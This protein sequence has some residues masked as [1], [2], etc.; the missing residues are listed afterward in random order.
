MIRFKVISKE[1]MSLFR[2]ADTVDE[3]FEYLKKELTRIHFGNA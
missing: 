2:F 3:A 1:D